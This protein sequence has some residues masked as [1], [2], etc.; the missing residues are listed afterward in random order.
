MC[1]ELVEKNIDDNPDGRYAG[2]SFPNKPSCE[3][4]REQIDEAIRKKD[5]DK[6]GYALANIK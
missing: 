1:G 2:E 4:T 6:R 5:F 3:P